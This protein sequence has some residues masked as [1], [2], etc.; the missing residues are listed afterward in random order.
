MPPSGE[1]LMAIGKF[2]Q[3]YLRPFIA[4]VP[5][6]KI[7][8]TPYSIHLPKTSNEIPL[9]FDSPHSGEA[10]PEDF[11]TKV[12]IDILKTGW[13]AF[14]EDLWGN[15]IEEGASLIEAHFPR[16]YIDPNRA[17][18]DI[19]LDLVEGG[20]PT[21]INPT[22][23]SM[24]GMGLIRQYAIP[25]V[26]M[27]Q[28]PL[29]VEAVMSRIKNYHVPYHNGLKKRLDELYEKFGQVWLI[30]CHSMKSKGNAMNIDNGKLRPDVVLGNDDGKCADSEFTGLVATSFR[31]RGY[32]VHLND[33]YKGGYIIKHY[34][35]PTQGRHSIQIEIN[36]ALYMDE[37]RFVRSNNF[38]HFKNDLKMITKD[39]SGFIK[40]RL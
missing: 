26:L 4:M 1:K 16:A 19:D 18:D 2:I 30:D 3:S 24:C 27:Y 8:P 28:N 13:D 23:Y 29:S 37:K 40:E 25:N 35:T 6:A 32:S 9:V 14:V 38:S 11:G 39:I 22:K 31:E 15:V 21:P 5:S 7:M 20:W 34:G 10:Y 12:D 33:P 36:R 17:P